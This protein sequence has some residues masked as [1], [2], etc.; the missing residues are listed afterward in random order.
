[1]LLLTSQAPQAATHCTRFGIICCRR[2]SFDRRLDTHT[3]ATRKPLHPGRYIFLFTHSKTGRTIP[4]PSFFSFAALQDPGVS[5]HTARVVFFRS[6]H[7]SS[8]VQI[9][10]NRLLSAYA[11]FFMVIHFFTRRTVA[12][13]PDKNHP[14]YQENGLWRGTSQHAASAQEHS[15]PDIALAA[16]HASCFFVANFTNLKLFSSPT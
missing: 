9:L 5:K 2:S 4:S 7:L 14:T 1:M 12:P 13:A 16:I 10:S 15:R 8:F 11:A 3:I 6:K